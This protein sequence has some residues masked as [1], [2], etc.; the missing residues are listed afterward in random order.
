MLSQL[1]LEA[2][3]IGVDGNAVYRF[4]DKPHAFQGFADYVGQFSGALTRLWK[5]ATDPARTRP[6]RAVGSASRGY[7]SGTV[8][9][10]TQPIVGGQMINRTA[11]RS[12]TR[13]PGSSRS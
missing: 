5:N 3:H 12:N 1:I 6:M 10:V 13:V 11:P 8:L 4:H 9:A 2:M 7:D